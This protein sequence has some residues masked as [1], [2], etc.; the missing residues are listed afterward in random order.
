MTIMGFRI[1]TKLNKIMIDLENRDDWVPGNM[2]G[3]R[4]PPKSKDQEE[5]KGMT[6]EVREHRK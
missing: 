6:V 5:I 3:N 1:Y 4:A 2:S